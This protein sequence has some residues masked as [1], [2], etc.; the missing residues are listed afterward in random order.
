VRALHGGIWNIFTPMSACLRAFND[1]IRPCGAPLSVP[2]SLWF[3]IQFCCPRCKCASNYSAERVRCG[4]QSSFFTALS[5]HNNSLTQHQYLF[6][7]TCAFPAYFWSSLWNKRVNHIS[8]GKSLLV[9][10]IRRETSACVC[11]G[12]LRKYPLLLYVIW[13]LL[14]CVA[15]GRVSR[16]R[17]ETADAESIWT[18][19]KILVFLLPN[20]KK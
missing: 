8:K 1:F 10:G 6:P 7:N 16:G 9:K 17:G 14:L 18:G 3:F 19:H 5:K 15:L 2:F 20:R 13:N 11:I 12:Y 4:T